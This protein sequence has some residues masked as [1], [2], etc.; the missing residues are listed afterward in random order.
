MDRPG[1][2]VLTP[3]L[4]AKLWGGRRLEAFGLALPPGEAIGEAVVSAPE[5]AIDGGPLAGRRLGEVV[6]ERPEA[7][8]GLRGLRATG[9]RPLFPL[10]VK[11]IDANDD[12]SIQVHPD[13]EAAAAFDSLGKTEAWYVLAARPGGALFLGLRPGVGLNELAA[14]SRAGTGAGHLMRRV[15][16][17]P[18]TT[19]LMPAGTVHALGAGVVVYEVQQPSAITYRL[20]DWGRV[21]ASGRPR[22]LH[23]E[24]AL[25]VADPS[26]WPEPIAPVAIPSAVGRRQLLVACP[27]FALERIALVAGEAAP[28]VAAESPQ[29][30][31]VLH[32]GAVVAADGRE[33]ALAAGQ[34]A[35]L[36]ASA[37]EASIRATAPTV[38]LRAWVPDEATTATAAM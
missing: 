13:D 7:A 32:G 31:T 18:Q 2:L 16:A 22:E 27:Y 5:A 20:D 26:R 1:P 10:L 25:A 34:T 33:A 35:A 30:V 6:A 12:L 28:L 17:V 24:A 3:R 4:D 8:L 21:D 36:L 29:T 38:L 11:L 23:V 15:P 14:A 37:R 9:G 19:V